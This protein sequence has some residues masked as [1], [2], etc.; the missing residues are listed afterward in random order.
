MS[1]EKAVAAKDEAKK[2]DALL[3]AWRKK[4]HPRIADLIDH[5]SAPLVKAAGGAV[6]AKSVPER[7]K[8]VLSMLRKPNATDIG[9]VLLTEWPG[10]WDPAMP[11]M[12]ALAKLPDDPRVAQAFAQQIDLTQYV[13]ESAINL[14]RPLFKR[15]DQLA[16][17]R[18]KELLERQLTR[19]KNTYYARNS[20]KLEERSVAAISKVKVPALTASEE[21]LLAQLE[22]PFATSTATK[23]ERGKSGEELLAAVYA[24]PSD[25]G[26]RAV[27]GD[28]LTQ[29]GDPRGE[30]ISLQLAPA[31]AKSESRMRSLI[32]QH[33]R[34]WAG[35]ISD[36]FTSGYSRGTEV[37]VF[38]AGFVSSC[39]VQG[40]VLGDQEAALRALLEHQEWRTVEKLV[41]WP[42]FTLGVHH[43]LAHR[44]FP[45][46]KELEFTLQHR[47]LAPLVES[48]AG[49]NLE[50]ITVWL[51]RDDPA[52]D[53]ASLKGVRHLTVHLESLP[54]VEALLPQLEVLRIQRG[55]PTESQWK[56][57]E[58]S[59]VKTVEYEGCRV[60]QNFTVLERL[61]PSPDEE[62]ELLAVFKNLKVAKAEGPRRVSFDVK[63]P[64]R[65][66]AQIEAVWK[67]LTTDFGVTFD[68]LS[69]GGVKHE[70]GS[71]PV[72]RIQVRCRN[73]KNYY[74][75]LSH[76]Q[77][78]G[79]SV[80]FW[81]RNTDFK[82][83]P[84]PDVERF[85][86]ALHSLAALAPKETELVVG[87]E[88]KHVTAKLDSMAGVEKF[89]RAL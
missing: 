44:N 6:K 29:Q 80:L 12:R 15:L 56:A 82:G 31:T 25:L 28:W 87:A 59:K 27:Y 1:L 86:G 23:K 83:I 14:Y 30:L 78:S 37:P 89:V 77:D 66:D 4:K 85:L 2:L 36:W 18:T 68:S 57:L 65:E 35:P 71:E 20:R 55:T 40:P 72:K 42:T 60:S 63:A 26:L 76:R 47:D 48:K 84:A 21:K 61:W 74:I 9:R 75:E 45:L 11:V 5:V 58:K 54:F 19:T 43:A 46:V 3:A 50:R 8:L 69:I 62:K 7:T 67:L 24:N 34:A 49:G 53:L 32:K 17:V 73:Q 81:H 22:A 79:A 52:V 38:K 64:L 10:T 88:G 39:L 16:D 70:L 13:S 33:W 41:T 51:T